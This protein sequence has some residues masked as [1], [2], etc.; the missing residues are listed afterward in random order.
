MRTK[1]YSL[2]AFAAIIA[3]IVSGL[4]FTSCQKLEED[5][6]MN[7]PNAYYSYGA[8]THHYQIRDV[9]AEFEHYI[10]NA[11]GTNAIRGGADNEVIQ[12][13]DQCYNHI[14]KDWGDISGTVN[15]VKRRH[16]DGKEKVIKTYT[17]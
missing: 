5:K 12:V 15:I 6:G 2:M 9:A 7:E 4:S 1:K 14:K 11:V 17:F 3:V 13:C 8:T 16:P 10:Q